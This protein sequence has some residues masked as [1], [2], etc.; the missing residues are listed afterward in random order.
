MGKARNS[1]SPEKKFRVSLVPERRPQLETTSPTEGLA[2][3]LG[4]IK[5][6]LAISH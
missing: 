3:P 1:K 4:I 5:L 2:I 6:P